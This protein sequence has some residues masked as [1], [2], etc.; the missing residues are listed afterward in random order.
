MRVVSKDAQVSVTTKNSDI[1]ENENMLNAV[2]EGED[3]E[4]N[5]NHKYV[6]DVFQ[7]IATDSLCM[8]FTGKNRPMIMRPIGDTTFMYLVMPMN[9]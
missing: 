2:V 7:V 9:K 5:F 6:Y 1:G 8:Q 4:V 3:I